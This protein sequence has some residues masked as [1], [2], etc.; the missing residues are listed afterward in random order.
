MYL[1]FRTEY[2]FR[3]TFAPI[4]KILDHCQIHGAKFAGIAD[5]NNTFGHV[6]W[7][8]ECLKRDIQ[9]IFG[10]TVF[11]FPQLI[12]ERRSP[13]FKTVLIARNI[14]GLREIYRLVDQSYQDFYYVPRVSAQTIEGL[15]QNV[16]VISSA[17]HIFSRKNIYFLLAPDTPISERTTQ[18]ALSIACIDNF[19]V[20][21]SDWKTFEK[22]TDDRARDVRTTPQFILSYSECENKKAI[23]NMAS[24]IDGIDF[25]IEPAKM[26]KISNNA[27]NE[28]HDLCISGAKKKGINIKKGKYSKRYKKEMK[29]I[30]DKKFSDYFLITADIVRYAKKIMCVGHSRGSAGGSLVCFLAGITEVNPIKYGLIFERFIDINRHDLPDIDIDFSQSKR[31]LVLSYLQDKYGKENVAQLANISRLQKKSSLVRY[32]KA[33]SVSLSEVEELKDTDTKLSLSKMISDTDSGKEL[34]KKYPAFFD[35][36]KIEHHAINSGVHAA[37]IIVSNKP[38]TDYCG[39]NSRD[40]QRIAMIDKD[41]AEEVGLLKID[42]LGLRTLAIFDEICE[43]RK[44]PYDFIHDIPMDDKK[45]FKVFKK[46]HY[47]GVFQF[48][49][50]TAK[51]L[52][53]QMAIKTLDDISTLSAIARPGP[54]MSG[55][56]KRYIKRSKG[57]KVKYTDNCKVFR[58]ITKPTF[59][60]LVYQEQVM[61]IAKKYAGLSWSEVAK[62]RKAVSKSKGLS[63]FERVFINGCKEKGRNKKKANKVWKDMVTNGEYLFNKSHSVAY[64]MISYLCA[65][66]KAHYPVEFTVATLNNTKDDNSALK[67]LREMVEQSGIKYQYFD[68]KH[69]Q[70]KW[71]TRK[72]ILYGSILSIDG[73]GTVAANKIIRIRNENNLNNLPAGIAK[74]IQIMKTPFRYLYPAKQLYGEYYKNSGC[75]KIIEILAPGEYRFIGKLIKKRVRDMNEPAL[76]ARRDGKIADSPSTFLQLTIEDDTD[77]ILCSVWSDEYEDIGKEIAEFGS[78][79]ESWY[80]IHGTISKNGFRGITINY[81]EEITK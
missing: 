8:K 49:G 80:L 28:L 63:E 74:K 52:A 79:N 69:S 47:A 24:L 61:E 81:I 14:K 39:I 21:A 34:V 16:I 30:Q 78:E 13:N 2:T 6:Q 25:L 31:K 38:V 5:H 72:G 36:G 65:Y 40:N 45:A 44:K 10:V 3:S 7:Q 23:Y 71:S 26:V 41:D 73:I 68:I 51:N 50:E 57:T 60:V 37:G 18:K 77:S 64:A 48:E 35:V 75:S 11:V 70:K 42:A 67:F 1:N 20:D 27:D 43:A 29:L 4:T 54:L 17:P 46:N 9:P 15:S 56:A 66:F 59:G 76:V 19:Y 22:I 58:K 12:K 33:L 55:G 32:A 62:I 53:A